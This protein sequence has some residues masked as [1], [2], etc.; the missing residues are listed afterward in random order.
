MMQN[1]TA[2]NLPLWWK[3]T[4]S[5]ELNKLLI[6]W[7]GDKIGY[8]PLSNFTSEFCDLTEQQQEELIPCMVAD[9][10]TLRLQE[11][12]NGEKTLQIYVK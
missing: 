6:N 10:A 8:V 1:V 2:E 4:G 12:A 3:E 5:K 9:G 11:K 7:I